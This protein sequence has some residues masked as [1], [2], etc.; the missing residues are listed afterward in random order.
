MPNNYAD[1]S[2]QLGLRKM[3]GLRGVAPAIRWYDSSMAEEVYVVEKNKQ[4]HLSGCEM[5]PLESDCIKI[6]YKSTAGGSY[7]TVKNYYPQTTYTVTNTTSGAD[8]LSTK[9]VGSPTM[10]RNRY[11]YETSYFT[12]KDG[13]TTVA[14]EFDTQQGIGGAN[15]LRNDYASQDAIGINN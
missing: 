1:L 5:T 9:I 11:G 4:I 8:I 14:Q 2:F 13:T 10:P 7:N 12:Y 3:A 6:R 15:L